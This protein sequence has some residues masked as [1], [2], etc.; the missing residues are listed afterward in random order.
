MFYFSSSD[1]FGTITYPEGLEGQISNMA[2]SNGILFVTLPKV[3]K[4]DAYRL[5]RCTPQECPV[6]FSITASVLRPL[7]VSYFAPRR[8]RTTREHPEVL[9]IECLDSVLILDV[10]NQDRISL[11]KELMTDGTQK[12]EFELA[13]NKNYLV[14]VSLPSL[15]EEYRMVN[16]YKGSISLHK[17]LPLYDYMLIRPLDL[18]FNDIGNLFFITAADL[19]NNKS[20]VMVYRLG[21]TLVNSLYDIIQ[22]DGGRG[23]IEL[24]VSG[25]VVNFVTIVKDGKFKMVKEYEHP[26]MVLED[27][28]F[29]I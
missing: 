9:F 11:L 1:R 27:E 4:I 19:R 16:L 18:E 23:D 22:V 20:V 29:N 26:S 15:I 10:D 5:D 17:K 6:E 14:I 3:K 8:V 7:G 2:V 12:G 13:V 25:G 24:E 21:N 28:F